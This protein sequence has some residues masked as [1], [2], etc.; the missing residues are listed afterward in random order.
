[1]SDVFGK[2]TDILVFCVVGFILPAFLTAFLMEEV[3]DTT[4]N[5][6]VREFA[7]DVA[8]KGYLDKERYETF[9]LELNAAGVLTETEVC[10]ERDLFAPEYRMRTIEDMEDYLESLWGGY[11]CYS[12]LSV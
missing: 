5:I 12:I 8:A 3:K 6:T 9:L 4:A 1:M 7:E 2:L 11:L 10:V